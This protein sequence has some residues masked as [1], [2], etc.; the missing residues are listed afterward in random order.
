MWPTLHVHLK[1]VP[2]LSFFFFFFTRRISVIWLQGKQPKDKQDTGK[3]E[4]AVSSASLPPKNSAD[5]SAFIF[6]FSYDIYQCDRE[7]CQTPD[8]STLSF[9]SVF[10]KKLIMCLKRRNAFPYLSQMFWM[11][12]QWQQ[13]HWLCLDSVCVQSDPF[14]NTKALTSLPWGS[15]VLIVATRSVCRASERTRPCP[16]SPYWL[17]VYPDSLLWQPPVPHLLYIESN[18]RDEKSSG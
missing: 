3:Y 9:F 2:G 15:L 14:G 13:A 1:Q 5:A 12:W 7:A 4:W 8:S 6:L 16:A 10:A 17:H 18:N 11:V